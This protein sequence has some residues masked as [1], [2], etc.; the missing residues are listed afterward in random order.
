MVDNNGIYIFF[1]TYFTSFILYLFF[2][3][4]IARE[5]DT[6]SLN[7]ERRKK[8]RMNRKV[9]ESRSARR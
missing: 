7:E 5:R 9:E 2:S 4:G 1:I 8:L 6:R 3:N